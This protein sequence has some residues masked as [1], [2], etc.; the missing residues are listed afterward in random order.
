MAKKVD[1]GELMMQQAP[2]IARQEM[3]KR[4]SNKARDV[5]PKLG[6]TAQKSENLS[7]RIMVSFTDVDAADLRSNELVTPAGSAAKD[8]KAQGGGTR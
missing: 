8:S 4:T 7:K 6:L 3:F 5:A 2:P 1:R